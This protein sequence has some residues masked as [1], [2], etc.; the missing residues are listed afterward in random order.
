MIK[1]AIRWILFAA[2]CSL[3]TVLVSAKETEEEIGDD[4]FYENEGDLE[5]TK[6]SDE[7]PD[8]KSTKGGDDSD[9]YDYYNV[10]F[11]NALNM[12]QEVQEGSR[13]EL[14]EPRS[15]E[16]GSGP[17]RILAQIDSGEIDPL[18]LSLKELLVYANDSEILDCIHIMKNMSAFKDLISVL[19]DEVLADIASKPGLF[20]RL[21]DDAIV[22]FAED[23]KAVALI[24]VGTLLEVANTRPHTIGKSVICN[25]FHVC[26][27]SL[28]INQKERSSLQ[29]INMHF[30]ERLPVHTLDMFAKMP[31]FI[32]GL[33]SD[34]KLK[35]IN[36]KR[37][38]EKL[39]LLPK[40]SLLSVVVNNWDFLTTLPKNK[41]TDMSLISRLWIPKNINIHIF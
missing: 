24:G 38:V 7:N 8:T 34:T 21:S 13:E 20:E 19:P 28:L 2:I 33:S 14:F 11:E 12:L 27:Q 36:N 10:N 18:Q 6:S 5:G 32:D 40:S 4:Y 22:A 35:L 37:I 16:C 25:V 31:M 29:T 1:T 23:D 26:K 15:F 39:S 17:S 41:V 3:S 30:S 9:Y